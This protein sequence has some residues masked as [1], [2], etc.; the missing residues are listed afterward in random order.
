VSAGAL[1]LPYATLKNHKYYTPIYPPGCTDRLQ[2]LDRRLFGVSKAYA[3]ERW[4]KQYHGSGDAKTPRRV[5]A[6][7]VMAVW[8]QISP[9]VLERAWDIFGWIGDWQDAVMGTDGEEYQMTM[10][11]EERRDRIYSCVRKS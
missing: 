2:P 8:E 7:N 10:T 11:M 6:A 3:C 4:R 9:D 5:I 1:R